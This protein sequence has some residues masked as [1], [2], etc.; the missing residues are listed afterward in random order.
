MWWVLACTGDTGDTEVTAT[1]SETGADSGSSDSGSDPGYSGLS[2]EGDRSCVLAP[3]GALACFD[4][5]DG[6]WS[7]SQETPAGLF[8]HVSAGGCGLRSGVIHCWDPDEHGT[9]VAPD[10]D[11]TTVERGAG[12]ACAPDDIG[13][14]R[15]W[16]RVDLLTGVFDSARV[17]GS[18]AVSGA[19]VCGVAA[20]GEVVCDGEQAGGGIGPYAQVA[21]GSAGVCA[22]D[23]EGAI[24][25]WGEP[26]AVPPEGNGY[27]ALTVGGG[28]V[29]ALDSLGVAHCAG[30]S[31][32]A[33]VPPDLPV[34][35][36]L[37]SGGPQVC[38]LDVTGTLHCWFDGF[39][40]LTQV[41]ERP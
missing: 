3:N 40:G 19:T 28:G 18:L 22:L 38:G 32:A 11:F 27:R 41:S 33:S 12:L 17:E 29:C 8:T 4:V 23:G 36:S 26:A 7:R 5:T 25:C 14:L 2:A 20:A 9:D 21:V 39:G 35:V 31:A 10:G 15:C 37:A 13:R 30:T 34:L 6:A 16:G 1:N 24:S